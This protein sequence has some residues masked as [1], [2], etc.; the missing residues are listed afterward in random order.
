MKV[1]RT[2]MCI[3]LRAWVCMSVTGCVTDGT[4]AGSERKSGA[5]KMAQFFQGLWVPVITG[6]HRVGI[7]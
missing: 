7:Q 1:T 5:P 2:E 4:V 6:P 3:S